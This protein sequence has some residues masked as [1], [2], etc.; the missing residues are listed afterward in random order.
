MIEVTRYDN[1]KVLINIDLVE[2]VEEC[3]E[4]ILTFVN[5]KQM[6]IRESKEEIVRK[7]IELKRKIYSGVQ[8]NT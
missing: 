1:T 2:R 7:S 5:G 4:T 3:P 6:I 8:W